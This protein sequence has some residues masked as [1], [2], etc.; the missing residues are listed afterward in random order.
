MQQDFLQG[1][2][3]SSSDSFDIARMTDMSLAWLQDSGWCASHSYV[4]GLI[5][6]SPAST[7]AHFF[8]GSRL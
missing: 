7:S 4:D 2:A 3:S 6:H 5:W 1:Q 8:T